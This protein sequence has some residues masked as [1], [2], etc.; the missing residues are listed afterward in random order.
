MVVWSFAEALQDP[1]LREQLTSQGL[2]TTIKQNM[3][4]GVRWLLET[5]KNGWAPNPNRQTKPNP[6]LTAQVIFILGRAEKVCDVLRSD[7]RYGS[8]KKQFLLD[9]GI[10]ALEPDV[11]FQVS[12]VDAWLDLPDREQ[13]LLEPMNFLW[14]PWSLIAYESLANDRSL[15]D[16]DRQLAQDRQQALLQKYAVVVSHVNSHGETFVLAEHLLCL[17]QIPKL[18]QAVK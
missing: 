11:D 1:G 18:A 10:P 3:D 8:A 5:H 17:G 15:A 7:L 13:V 9:T 2:Y 12:N 16:K 6:G 14:Y 4:N